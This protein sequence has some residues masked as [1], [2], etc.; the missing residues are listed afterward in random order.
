MTKTE[1][2]KDAKKV[3]VKLEQTNFTGINGVCDAP[4]LISEQICEVD[5]KGCLELVIP[6]AQGGGGL[7]CHLITG[8]R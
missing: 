8:G 3:K 7:S 6:D 2:F 1:T 4:D 5:E